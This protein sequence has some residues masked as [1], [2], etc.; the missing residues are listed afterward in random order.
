MKQIGINKTLLVGIVE[1]EPQIRVIAK[2]EEYL[3]LF[4]I[5]TSRESYEGERLDTRHAVYCKGELALYCKD[6][7]AAGCK[8]YAEGMLEYYQERHEHHK[9]VMLDK[10]R[11]QIRFLQIL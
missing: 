11:I 5:V 9:K 10:T 6:K 7:L 1:N 3:A 2:K 4:T 8:V